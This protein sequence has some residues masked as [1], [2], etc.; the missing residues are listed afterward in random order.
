MKKLLLVMV[1]AIVAGTGE[2][3][4]WTWPAPAAAAEL[5]HGDAL[6]GDAFKKQAGNVQVQSSGVVVQVL[7]DVND[8]DRQ[9]R[10]ML[11]LATGQTIMIVHN[12]SLAPRIPLL[13]MG[14]VVEFNGLYEWNAQGGAVRWTH[15]DPAGW[16]PPGWL[17]HNGRTFQ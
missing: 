2:F 9:Q 17:R 4:Q 14:D 8:G 10:F 12:V 3:R 15:R 6:L 13:N 7:P 1:L 16:H 11:G 5:L